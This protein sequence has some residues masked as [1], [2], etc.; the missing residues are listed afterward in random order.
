MAHTWRNLF[1]FFSILKCIFVISR[2]GSIQHSVRV[3]LLPDAAQRRGH[4]G[5]QQDRLLT[6]VSRVF[7]MRLY[8]LYLL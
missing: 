2:S 3:Q 6:Q 1:F 4:A 7:I 8:F 5:T